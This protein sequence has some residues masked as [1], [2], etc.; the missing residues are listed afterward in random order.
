M[1]CGEESL[2][3]LVVTGGDAA[4]VF[5]FIEEAFDA[6]ALPVEDLV[7]MEFLAA[8]VDRRDDGFHAIAG[9]TLANAIG[10]IA[11]VQRGGLQHVVDWQA[12][13]ERLKLAAVV[14]L[15]FGQVERHAAVFIDG[16]GVDLGA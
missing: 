3:E 15:A 16:G 13:I 4:E 1:E 8:G 12:L 5:D 9:Q 14:G 10:V 6:V 7:V 11:L 2:L